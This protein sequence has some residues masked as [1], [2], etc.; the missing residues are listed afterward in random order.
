MGAALIGT[1]A[2]QS[3][4]MPPAMTSA[5]TT[6]DGQVQNSAGSVTLSAT[7]ACTLVAPTSGTKTYPLLLRVTDSGGAQRTAS[8]N[9]NVGSN[10]VP[11]AS[12]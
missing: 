2:A 1:G 4:L 3:K 5:G 12:K 6:F 10:S 7:A 11:T 8:V 9:V